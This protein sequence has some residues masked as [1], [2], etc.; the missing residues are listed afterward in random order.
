M[1]ALV[2]LVV[3]DGGDL[4]TH[5][6][7]RLDR[8]LV[9]E[10]CRQQR[11]GADQ[12]TR[13][14]RDGLLTLGRRGGAH[15]LQVR[16]EELGAAR[17]CAV[18][19]A[20]RAGRA[21]RRQVAMEVVD[22]EQLDLG[23]RRLGFGRRSLGHGSPWPSRVPR[24]SGGLESPPSPQPRRLVLSRPCLLRR[25]LGH[26]WCAVPRKLPEVTQPLQGPEHELTRTFYG[27]RVTLE[28][29]PS[30]LPSA[31][32]RHHGTR[33][34]GCTRAVDRSAV[35][36]H[37]ATPR[38]RAPRRRARPRIRRATGHDRGDRPPERLKP[39]RVRRLVA[40]SAELVVSP[41]PDDR[42][43]VLRYYACCSTTAVHGS[44]SGRMDS[45]PAAM[46]SQHDWVWR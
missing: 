25:S 37:V 31:C 42:A 9:V 30:P 11:R 26:R 20:A 21:V 46:N 36:T 22:G 41:Q 43:R 35:G 32:L 16:R 19:V 6:A 40:G 28:A 10:R 34:P 18:D 23:V 39:D 15:L 45:S 2:E 27:I 3:T 24:P 38:R 33:S 1:P 29:V 13:G 7:Q 12:V 17:G 5:P 44:A 8:R 4:Q 14:D